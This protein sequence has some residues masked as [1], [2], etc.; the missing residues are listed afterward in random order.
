MNLD[1]LTYLRSIDKGDMLAY[2]DALPDQF[3][4]AWAL[5][6]TLPLPETHRTPRQIVICGMGGSAIGADLMAALVARTSPAPVSVIRGYDLPASVTGP[7]TLVILSSHSGNTEET[8]SAA[9]QALTRN[10]R[11]LAVTTGGK[12][13][14]H[15]QSHGYPL[16]QFSYVSQ[17]RAAIGWSLG[18]QI[19]LAARLN[20]A[21]QLEADLR[22][23]IA[24]LR[25]EREHYKATSP[26]ASNPAKRG[27]GQLMGRIPVFYGSGIF[28]PVAQRWKCQL[29]E[30]AQ[31]WAQYE[32]LPEA[33]HNTIVGIDF[34]AEEMSKMAAVFICS[35][36]FDQP[37]VQLRYKLTNKIYLQ[38]GIM[39]DQF[40]PRGQSAVAQM[41]HAIQ[42]GDYLSVYTALAYGADPT[43]IVPIMMIKEQLSAH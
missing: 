33:N 6:Q 24:L 15:A 4:N 14:Q 7:E 20:L 42:Y 22:E 43:E 30:N 36:T 8:L 18:L 37:R 38:Y 40:T 35:D 2:T 17:P 31:V 28:A 34:P 26:L 16:W 27:A 13:A 9:D 10:V 39:V 32:I 3:E 29:N 41:L 23:G 1:D 5:A 19:G 25:E 11:M 12:L 21:P